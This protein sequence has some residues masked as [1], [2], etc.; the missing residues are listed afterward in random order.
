MVGAMSAEVTGRLT[1][2]TGLMPGPYQHIGTCW[3]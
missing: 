3:V 2:P 1:M